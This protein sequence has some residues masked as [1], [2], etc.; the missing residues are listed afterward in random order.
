MKK[1]VDQKVKE[2]DTLKLTV[3]VSAVPEPEIKWF[4][5]GEEVTSDTRVKIT[6]DSQRLENYDLT[7]TLLK[8][9]DGGV[10][11]V[12]ASNDLGFVSSKSKIIVLSKYRLICVAYSL[13]LLNFESL[14]SKT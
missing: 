1:L 4:K 6:R 3:Q 7:L 11:E 2:G 5:D 14:F 8:G 9:T 13:K 10:Y 12:R